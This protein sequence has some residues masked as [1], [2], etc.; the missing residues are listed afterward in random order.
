[1]NRIYARWVVAAVSCLLLAIAPVVALGQDRSLEV[2][3]WQAQADRFRLA[4]LMPESPE[5]WALDSFVVRRKDCGEFIADIA[6]V[7]KRADGAQIVLRQ[8][9]PGLCAN[10]GEVDEAG[11]IGLRG[12][13]AYFLWAGG[14]GPCFAGPDAAPCGPDGTVAYADSLAL[15]WAEFGSQAGVFAIF[16]TL[17]N[18]EPIEAFARTLREI[19]PSPERRPLWRRQRGRVVRV[20]RADRVQI[21]VQ[22]RNRVVAL[23]GIRAAVQC[24][25]DVALQMTRRLLPRGAAVTIETDP[26]L[27]GNPNKLFVYR[28]AGAYYSFE[29]IN[30]RLVDAGLATVAGPSRMRSAL[31][32]Q[33]RSARQDKK[34]VYGADCTG[35]PKP[36]PAPPAPA[37]PTRPSYSD[38][39]DCADFPLEDGTTAKQYLRY[40]PSD[41]SG[42]DGDGDGRACE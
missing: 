38:A 26:V 4:L 30:S 39:Y 13:I 42:L 21:R 12:R 15:T 7:Y 23:G 2:Q 36:T 28:R 25:A 31:L 3:R 33:Q 22:G 35:R 17:T 19:A 9:Y 32:Q 29:T 14:G 20:V 18:T 11:S 1:M 40:Y 10:F 8:G 6:A 27:G 24:K 41:P 16:A 37:R 34:G 5:G